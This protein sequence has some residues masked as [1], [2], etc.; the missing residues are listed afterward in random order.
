ME[1]ILIVDTETTGLDPNDG[2]QVLE[3]GTI[4]FNVPT[5]TILHMA[6]T[7][8]YAE[9]NPAYEINR[10]DVEATK[11]VKLYLSEMTVSL[12]CNLIQNSD[13]IVAHNAEFDRKWIKKIPYV[14]EISEPAKW[15]CTK[16][17]VVWP[18]R[19]GTPLNLVHI[20]C[21]LGVPIITNHRALDDCLLLCKAIDRIDDIDYFLNESG[22]GRLLYQAHVSYDDRKL[23]KDNGFKWDPE[24]KGWFILMKP[25]DAQS[26]PFLVKEVGV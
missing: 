2:G 10:I 23:A 12:I 15:I 16:E 20:C 3:I 19:K 21:D 26:M 4:L 14:G 1:N 18:L 25:D 6:S 13:A 9:E 22:K 5:R 8:F 24:K 7:L 11:K 17:D